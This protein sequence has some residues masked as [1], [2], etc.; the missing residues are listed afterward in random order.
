MNGPVFVAAVIDRKTWT[1]GQSLVGHENIVEVTVRPILPRSSPHTNERWQA[2]NPLLFLRDP[3]QPP[4]GANLC[5]LLALSARNGISI[6]ITSQN[7][8]VV[9]LDEVFDRDVLDMSWWVSTSTSR[10]YYD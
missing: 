4:T 3:S 7:Q 2:F 6:W 8:P 1:S 10:P 9:V 5:T